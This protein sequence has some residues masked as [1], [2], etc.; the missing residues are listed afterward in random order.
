MAS[1]SRPKLTEQEY[2]EIERSAD[3]KSE[4]VR[5]AMYAMSG[6][7]LQRSGI[8]RNILATLHSILRAGECQAFGSDL[9]VRVSNSLYT[10]PDVTVVCGKPLLSDAEQDCLMNPIAIFEVL[11]PTTETYDRGM[12]FQHY[13]TIPSLREYI[14]VEQDH[15]QIEQY[16]RQ[17]ADTWTLRDHKSLDAELKMDSIGATLP[18]RLIYEGVDLAS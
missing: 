4:L 16:I 3:F 7:S 5:G 1:S 17:D 8:A 10:Y 11:S 15:V 12:K 13:R 9:R 18:L 6:G 2:L 14:L